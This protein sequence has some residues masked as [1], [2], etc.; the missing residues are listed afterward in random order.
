MAFFQLQRSVRKGLKWSLFIFDY[1]VCQVKTSHT[2]S[3]S[4]YGLMRFLYGKTQGKSQE[5]L[6]RLPLILFPTTKD[7]PCRHVV[8]LREVGYS[9]IDFSND[10]RALK[11]ISELQDDLRNYSVYEV[12][13]SNDAPSQG[14]YESFDA[15]VDS[16]NRLA[17]R[18][19]HYRHDV[20]SCASAWK[21]LEYSDVASI[22]EQYLSCKPLLTSLDCWYVA[23]ISPKVKSNLFYSAAAQTFHYDMDWIKFVKFFFNLS[24][25]TQ[26]NGAFEFIPGTHRHKQSTHYCDGRF[27]D[28]DPAKNSIVKALG[29]P[30]T[31]FVAD[32]SGLHR[33]GRAQNG[34]RQVLQIE[35]AVSS[36]G[37]KFQYDDINIACSQ[38]IPW[39][40]LSPLYSKESRLM[41]LFRGQA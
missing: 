23:P 37:A 6:S 7:K 12:R 24:S 9:R 40:S 21:L 28:L 27:E 41:S 14:I 39:H 5:W 29:R 22:A 13:P 2:S 19:N 10:P 17:P 30:G 4:S 1:L 16:L 11:I 31:C 20:C 3:K 36:F 8:E 33:D 35:F 18:I 34:F 38:S 26:Q 25:A 32:T 15:C